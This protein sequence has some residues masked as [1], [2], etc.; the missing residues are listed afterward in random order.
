MSQS[1]LISS[2]ERMVDAMIQLAR[3]AKSHRVIVADSNR[4]EVLFLE[5]HRRG[6]SRVTTKA[7][8]AFRATDTTWL[9][10]PGATTR[11][12][13]SKRHS[14]D[15]SRLLGPAGVPWSYGLARTNARPIKSSDWRWEGWVFPSRRV[16]PARR[17]GRVCAAHRGKP[18]I[19]GR[20]RW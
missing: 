1:S 14:T 10:S 2:A 17:V 12:K 20:V 5:L 16:P 9:L 15:S 11:S 18:V 6:Y 4:A 7:L 19:T 8:A 3:A 13:L